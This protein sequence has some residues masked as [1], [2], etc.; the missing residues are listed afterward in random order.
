MIILGIHGG[1]TLGQHDPAAAL[2]VDGELI[3][4]VEEERLMRIKT[5]R[6]MLPLEA[7]SAVMREAGLS[8]QDVDI[9][10]HPGETYADA[11][12]RI[13]SYMTHY[14]GH[15]P[16]LSLINHQTAH[17]ASAFYPSEFQDAMVLSYDAYGDRLSAALAVADRAAGIKIL[18]TRDNINS[19]G[20]FYATMTSFLGFLPGEDEYKVMG[21]AP[22]GKPQFDLS[23]FAR[24]AADGYFV[25]ADRCI[26]KDPSPKSNFEPFYNSEIIRHLG[27]PRK[28]GDPVT[29]QHRNIAAST[30]RALED[31]ACSLVRHLSQQTGKR[32]LCLA[33][34]VALN[35]SANNV[36]RQ[37]DCVDRI[38]VQP[39]ASDRGLALGCALQAAVE[40]GETLKPIRHVFYGPARTNEDIEQ[41]LKLTGFYAETVDDPAMVAAEFLAEGQ[42]VGW[43]QGRSEFGPRALGHRSILANPCRADMKDQINTR[44]K[45]REEFRPFAPSVIEDRCREI[46]EMDEPSPYM[47]VAFN[48]RDGWGDRLP[49]TTHIND[50]ARVQ[51]VSE[52]VDPLYHQMI[53]ALGSATGAPVV[54]N[55]SFNIKGQPIVETPLDAIST[56]AGTGIDSLVIGNY[57]LRKARVTRSNK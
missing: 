18:E 8:I 12:L 4:C 27:E 55:T 54:L 57:L 29:D 48:V 3:A 10:A 26:R 31:C 53:S 56:F 50:T 37:L 13:K 45:F 14:F 34:G 24:P 49:A 51:T 47:T 43:Y 40:A 6:G 35:C 23:F 22:Y 25:D 46:F 44:V 39:A 30:Q 32:N 38:F 21:L 17:L 36:L 16:E 2:I 19:L 52:D 15:M 42:I 7:I 33:G 5:P 20:M 11:P 41:A 28:K 1:V 9:V